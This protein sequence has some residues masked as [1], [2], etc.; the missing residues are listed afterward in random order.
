[1]SIRP[2]GEI[3]DTNWAHSESSLISLLNNLYEIFKK[4]KTQKD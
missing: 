2:C 1:M 4:E 3:E